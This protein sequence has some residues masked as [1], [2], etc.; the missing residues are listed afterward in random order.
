[1]L[2][3]CVSRCTISSLLLFS[4]SNHRVA[5]R[6]A[7]RGTSTIS[8]LLLS[9]LSNRRVTKLIP[10]SRNKYNFFTFNF[11]ISRR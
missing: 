2:E 4:L 5:K 7:N 3:R 11:F 1:M 10:V 8:F 6:F 9:T